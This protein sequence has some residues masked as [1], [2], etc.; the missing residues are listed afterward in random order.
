MACPVASSGLEQKK[1]I[2]NEL[3]ETAWHGKTHDLRQTK[4]QIMVNYS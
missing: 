2:H 1:N 3:S 4:R